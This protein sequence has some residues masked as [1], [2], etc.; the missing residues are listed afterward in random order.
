M[1][2]PSP[3]GD[4]ILIPFA[5]IFVSTPPRTMTEW[6]TVAPELLYSSMVSDEAIPRVTVLPCVTWISDWLV[7]SGSM[8]TLPLAISNEKGW[9][10]KFWFTDFSWLNCTASV[11]SASLGLSLSAPVTVI[12]MPGAVRLSANVYSSAGTAVNR[13]SPGVSLSYWGWAV[14]VTGT[15]SCWSFSLFSTPAS[16]LEGRFNCSWLVPD[17]TSRS[18]NLASVILKV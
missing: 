16:R 8:T 18:S 15:S 12:V 7:V 2:K 6:L 9:L 5:V 11:S 14:Q 13:Y 17:A 4:L 3:L 10:E 1:E